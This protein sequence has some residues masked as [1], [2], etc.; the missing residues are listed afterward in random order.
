[1]PSI[2]VSELLVIIAIVL[3]CSLVPLATLVG[4]F[5]VYARLKRIEELMNRPE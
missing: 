1:M 3:A 2:G 5:L 4:V